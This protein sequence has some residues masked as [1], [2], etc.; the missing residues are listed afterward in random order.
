LSGLGQEPEGIDWWNRDNDPS[1]RYPG[2]LHAI[3]LDNQVDD[4]N[5]WLKHYAV[6]YFCVRDDDTDG[7][8]VSDGDEVYLYNSSPLFADSDHDGVDDALDNCPF[9][10]N[11]NQDDQDGDGVGDG[12]DVDRDGDGQSNGDEAA[13]GSNPLDPGSVAPDLDAD[14][15]PDC[16]D[17]DD[18]G[19]GQSDAD[20]IACGS[21]PLDAESLSPDFDGD[22]ILDCLDPDDDDD[23]VVDEEDRCPG[24]LVP[25]PVIPSSGVLKR[26]RYSLLDDDLVFDRNAVGEDAAPAFTTIDTG[27]CN[28]SQIADALGLGRSHYESGLPRGVLEEWIGSQP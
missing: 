2:Q 8:G 11:P 5:I 1:S 27:G 12:C 23:G 14:G 4:D 24:T 15:T 7:D 17:E 6:D 19:D 9:V 21:D 26:N 16:V 13:C 28:P 10:S 18:D 22:A 25:D 3:L 20:E